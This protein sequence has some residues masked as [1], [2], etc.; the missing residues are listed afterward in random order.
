L[1]IL[2]NQR[3]AAGHAAGQRE[4]EGQARILHRF[5]KTY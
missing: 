4:Q 1:S 2:Q 3:I 5:L